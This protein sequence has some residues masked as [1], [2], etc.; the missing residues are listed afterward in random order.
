M[1]RC[2]V[3]FAVFAMGIWALSRESH[4]QE[5]QD[6]ELCEAVFREYGVRSEVCNAPQPKPQPDRELTAQDRESHIFF[7]SGGSRLSPQMERQVVLLAGVLN[8]APMK[9]ACLRLTGHSDASGGR[10]ANRRLSEQR[11]EVVAAALRLRLDRGDRVEEVRGV[12]EETP[13]E[14]WPSTARENRRVSIEARHCQ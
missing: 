9:D 3:F 14:G 13:L 8:T 2:F 7:L 11:A 4:A 1:L 10:D 12:G 5:M 6:A